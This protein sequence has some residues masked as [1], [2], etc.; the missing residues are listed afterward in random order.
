MRKA[1]PKDETLKGRKAF[2]F[3]GHKISHFPKSIEVCYVVDSQKIK[4]TR[5]LAGKQSCI[6]SK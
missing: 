3:G 1:P 2:V 6:L 5:N 4:I